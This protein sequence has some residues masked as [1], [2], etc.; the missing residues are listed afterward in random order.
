M[1]PISNDHKNL[2]GA[3]EGYIFL[4]KNINANT[5]CKYASYSYSNSKRKHHY[6]NIKGISRVY[7]NKQVLL[8]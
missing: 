7:P 1:Y 8:V 6:G 2:S 5:Y 3:V 4:K